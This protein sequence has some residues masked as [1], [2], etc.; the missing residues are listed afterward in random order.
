MLLCGLIVFGQE[1]T[2]EK[3]IATLLLKIE[4]TQ[5]GEKLQLMD[6]L[7]RFIVSQTNYKSDSI[8]K[9]TVRY[10]LA[11]DSIGI[12]TWHTGNLI[13]Y[14]NNIKG[15]PKKGNEL[16]LAF[17]ETAN[18][19]HNYKALAKFYIEGADSY[20]FL[21]DHTTSIKY[22]DLAEEN[23][24]KAKYEHYVG[25]A[26]LYKAATL[27][28][29]GNFP[30]SSQLLQEASKIFQKRKDTYNIISARNSL[31]IL[32][33]Q[34]SFFKEAKLERDE[35]IALAKQIKSYDHLVSF[36]YNAATDAFKQ[37]KDREQ[38][39]DL[40]L[41]L[42]ASK[43]GRNFDYY[44]P[45]LLAS[46]SIAYSNADSIKKA[47]YFIKEIEK[48]PKQNMEG[49]NRER[50]IDA[51]KHLAF[52]NKEY[53]K[54]LKYGKEHLAVKREGSHFEEIQKSEK[55]LADVYEAMG[56]TSLAYTHFKNY[57]AIKDSIGNV[58]KVRGL[59]YYQTLYETEKR[60]SK[61]QAQQKDID[62]LDAKN[63][64][65]NQLILF[66][67]VG[68]VA[69][70]IVV[71][72]ARSRNAAKKR[73][74]MQEGFSQDL[75][76]AQEEERTRVARELHDSV[77]QKLMLLTKQT[78]RFGDVE[79]DSLAGNTL[80]ELRSISR[81]L[82][83]AALEKL[84]ITEAIKSMINEVDANTNIFF[85]NEIEN[86][87]HLLTKESSLHLYRIIQEILNNMVKHADAKAASVKIACKKNTIEAVIAD[88]GKGFEFSEKFK[89]ATS[90]GMKTLMERAK[91][92]KSNLEI[93]SKSNQGTTIQL[94]IPTHK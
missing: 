55:F 15:N 34:N 62:L 86:I 77:G 37:H 54:A 74:L 70:F 75:I 91:I 66:G 80:D 64:I 26:K 38:I 47:E 49:Q 20:Y 72:L 79:M 21:E 67:G 52:A 36:Y 10:A 89:V 7:S 3:K 82:H 27:S 23:A 83:P 61:I 57:Q 42:E 56:N 85:T 19:T 73:Q 58:Q 35:A 48:N 51:L 39:E 6:S 29:L 60:D 31:S 45:I 24:K 14:Q 88:N 44:E 5:K 68:L 65:Q 63:R 11:L 22:Y 30:E 43:K 12:A 84:G 50:Y 13:N 69:I 90:L 33:S 28:F 92:I 46:L 1:D 78:K 93:K 18:K 71:V 2:S 41:A 16:F 4:A 9:E 17:L 32:Y 40:K 76:T 25:L 94:I 53:P 87:D 8:V 59:S 81:G